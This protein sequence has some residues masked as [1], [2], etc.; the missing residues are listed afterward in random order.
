MALAEVAAYLGVSRQAAFYWS[1]RSGFP[2]PAAVLKLGS[3]WATDAIV[4]FKAAMDE[5][6]RRSRNP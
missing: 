2:A 3:V 6:G 1:Q 5:R 4:E